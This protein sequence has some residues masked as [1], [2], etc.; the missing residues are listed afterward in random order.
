MINNWSHIILS[1]ASTIKDAMQALNNSGLRITLIVD[2]NNRLIGTITDGD[3][4]RGLLGG[5]VFETPVSLAMNCNPVSVS[6]DAPK[7]A[8]HDLLRHASV[9]AVP[10]V[11]DDNHIVGLE[12]IDSVDETVH[13]ETPIV[14][15]AGGFGKRLHPLTQDIPKPM[16]PIGDKPILEHIIEDF[17][18]QGFNNFYITTHYKT[19]IIQDYFKKN[20]IDVNIE[21]V[22]EDEPLGTAGALH[23]LKEKIH[24]DFLV[25]NADLLVK[26]N[27]KNLLSFHQKHNEI[28]TICVKQHTYQVP[29]GVVSIDNAHVSHIIEKPSY[30]HFVN[31]GIYCLQKSILD[32]FNEKKYMDMTT[33]L[34][35]V[36]VE[37]KKVCAFPIHEYWIDIG[38]MDDFNNA[39]E[40][41]VSY[42]KDNIL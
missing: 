6:M 11:D 20:P 36:I 42:L 31:S 24:S 25:M 2:A 37:N 22:V 19:K 38:S 8:I 13:T 35:N 23:F 12:T 5:L 9:L 14:L 30:S 18:N 41:Y 40:D 34:K 10:V 16:L 27:F 28:A 4:R 17:K 21:Y 15:M 39:Q 33:L 29:Y 1:P 32:F 7:E 26:T 3:I